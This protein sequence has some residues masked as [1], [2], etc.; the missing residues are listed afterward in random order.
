M[1]FAPPP[2]TST[3]PPGRLLSGGTTLRHASAMLSPAAATRREGM[4]DGT[5][6]SMWSAYGTRTSSAI[7]PPHGPL[8]EPNPNAATGLLELVVVAHF[9]VSPARQGGHVPHETAHGTITRSPTVTRRTPGPTATTSA[10]HSCPIANGPWE[11]PR[12]HP[13][14][15]TGSMTRKAMPACS[16][17]E[18]GR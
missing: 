3:D 2:R 7:I 6:T 4:P 17:R 15:T 8:A 12:P 5:V 1:L 9:D 14:A 10:T 16:A 13:G 11:G 18:T